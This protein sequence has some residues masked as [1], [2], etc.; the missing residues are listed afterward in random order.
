LNESKFDSSIDWVSS[1]SADGAQEDT[2]CDLSLFN[3]DLAYLQFTSGSTAVPR[4]VMISHKNV[5][6][7]LRYIDVSTRH[8]VE[9]VVVSWLPHFHDMGLLG[10]ILGPLYRG[11]HSILMSPASFLRRPISWLNAISKFQATH[12]CAPDFAY[13]L[14]VR[15]IRASDHEELDLRPWRVAINGSERIRKTTLDAFTNAFRGCGFDP[16]AFRP[17]YGL[18]EATLMVSCRAEE[19]PITVLNVDPFALENGYVRIVSKHESISRTLVS[20][21]VV[22]E[23]LDVRIVNVARG[24]EYE[25]GQVGEI[26]V[27]GPSVGI[28]YWNRAEETETT[29]RTSLDSR[30]QKYLRT[31]D[32]G[33][34]WRGELYISGRLKDMIVIRG[35]NHFAEDIEVTVASAYHATRGGAC[36]AF[37]ID[38]AGEEHLIV[39]QELDGRD[40]G[41]A[42]Y[43][44]ASIRS[45]IAIEHGIQ[46]HAISL[47]QVGSI[48]RT[49]SG[50]VQRSLCRKQFLEHFWSNYTFD[51]SL[52]THCDRTTVEPNGPI[53]KTVAEILGIDTEILEPQVLLTSYGLDSLMAAKLSMRLEQDL[54]IRIPAD[55]LLDSISLND[56]QAAV[57]SRDFQIKSAEPLCAR[58]HSKPL[59]LSLEEERLWWLNKLAPDGTDQTLSVGLRFEGIFNFTTLNR[60][61]TA[62]TARHE[63]LRTSF[64]NAGGQ[65]QRIILSDAEIQVE[66]TIETFHQSCANI[67]FNLERSSLFRV[68]LIRNSETEL[69]L[70]LSAHHIISDAQSLL[71]LAQELGILYLAFSRGQP[72]ALPQLQLTYGDFVEWQRNR[73]TEDVMAPDIAYW[74]HQLEGVSN[75][76][77]RPM[78]QPSMGIRPTTSTID[79]EISARAAALLRLRTRHANV[80]PFTFLTTVFACVMAEF[81][82]Q[83]DLLIGVPVNGRTRPELE[84][85]V[86]FFAH[87]LPIRIRVDRDMTFDDLLRSVRQTMLDAYSHQDIPFSRIMQAASIQR[88]HATPRLQVMLNLLRVPDLEIKSSDFTISWDGSFSSPADLDLFLTLVERNENILCSLQYKTCSFDEQDAAQIA[89]SFLTALEQSL[90]AFDRQS[91]DRTLRVWEICPPSVSEQSPKYC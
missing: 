2:L 25:E 23:S 90:A 20:C 12:S 29:F 53:A 61:L 28:G 59:R 1:E 82:R 77:N 55:A 91:G 64:S 9:S 58:L 79:F 27:S 36:S 71:I 24:Q 39:L 14:C 63:A 57:Q 65:L 15:N 60:C 5:L 41:S 44:A 86:G 74:A 8:S 49:S 31:G 80:T 34:L 56:L 16:N 26:L 81:V 40:R 72:I 4:G 11:F 84:N 67:A 73:Q 52:N 78:Q 88:K 7:N 50:K 70:I 17:A 85:I 69:H 62:L 18:A 75:K 45:A 54:N 51:F 48:P 76:L 21:G 10:G 68:K 87:P 19:D 30:P 47:V 6:E 46:V 35:R 13:D 3:E 22:C 42:N 32:L 37:S 83:P 33:F 43:I 38:H 89:E 66:E